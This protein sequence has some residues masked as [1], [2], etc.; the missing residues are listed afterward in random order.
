[1]Q[2]RVHDAR[3]IEADHQ[4]RV[5]WRDAGAARDERGIA[6]EFESGLLD[7][8]LG[9]RRSDHRRDVALERRI[10]GRSRRVHRGAAMRRANLADLEALA[11]KMLERN[12]LYVFARPLDPA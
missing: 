8:E 12:Q 6:V 10:D 5:L 3:G 11:R 4:E 2:R 9:V 1:M 7:R